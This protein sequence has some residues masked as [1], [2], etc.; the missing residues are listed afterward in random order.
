MGSRRPL[1]CVL[2]E[3]TRLPWR[4]A[5]MSRPSTVFGRPAPHLLQATDAA[6]IKE[7]ATKSVRKTRENL[8]P[9]GTSMKSPNPRNINPDRGAHSNEM[10]PR[11]GS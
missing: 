10:P 5:V 11:M 4:I 2:T 9:F 6:C 7:P 1:W 8:V 3:A